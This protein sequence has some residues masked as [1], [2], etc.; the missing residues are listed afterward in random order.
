MAIRFVY[1]SWSTYFIA[2][3][4]EEIDRALAREERMSWGATY[5]V[6]C[7]ES[8]RV[9]IG[10]S[11]DL[12]QRLS[13]LQTGSPTRLNLIAILDVDEMRAQG[14]LAMHRLHGEWFEWT[15]EVAAYVREHKVRRR[16]LGGGS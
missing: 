2:W 12:G 1:P 7:S 4:N 9:K 3:A 14:E 15:R 8:K 10:R 5:V 6:Q 11:K 16:R 13:N